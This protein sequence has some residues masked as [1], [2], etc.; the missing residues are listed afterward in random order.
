MKALAIVA[1]IFSIIAIFIPVY[2]VFLAMLT[3]VL[4]LISFRS[5]PT[6]SGVV[7]GVN[8]INT[9]FLSPSI[10]ASDFILSSETDTS[11]AATE[12]GDVYWFF[13]GFHVV[14]LI[15]AIIWKAVRGKPKLPPKPA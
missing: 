5:E 7:F 10:V 9:S 6:F 3:S 11:P 1:M 12:S 14:L 15:A 8:I 2:G 13:V 4:A